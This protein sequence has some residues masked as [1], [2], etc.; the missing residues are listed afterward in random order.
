[1]RRQGWWKEEYFL[2]RDAAHAQVF[3]LSLASRLRALG[4]GALS[5]LSRNEAM[6]RLANYLGIFCVRTAAAT[7]LHLTELDVQF[8]LLHMYQVT[9]ANEESAWT[10]KRNADFLA[11]QL[12]VQQAITA[13]YSELVSQPSI[14]SRFWI[15][16]LQFQPHR[17]VQSY[18]LVTRCF[19]R[20][21]VV[22]ANIFGRVALSV[23]FFLVVGDT[24][25]RNDESCKAAGSR[26]YVEGVVGGLG[27][28]L[29]F[30]CISRLLQLLWTGI[31]LLFHS[32]E[33]KQDVQ[34]DAESRRQ[35]VTKWWLQ[36]VAFAALILLYSFG[37]CMLGT[38]YVASASDEDGQR[39]LASFAT[40][41]YD[42]E[43]EGY[44]EP[45]LEQKEVEGDAQMPPLEEEE[46]D[47]DEQVVLF[48]ESDEDDEFGPV[49]LA[50]LPAFAKRNGGE[51][52]SSITMTS[53]S[54]RSNSS[55]CRGSEERTGGKRVAVE[56][57]FI[58]VVDISGS[59]CE[60]D[61]KQVKGG[62]ISRIDAV[63]SEVRQLIELDGTRSGCD[64]RM[65]FITFSDKA[66]IHFQE[67][68]LPDAAKILST[69]QRPMPKGQTFYC[70]GLRA[71]A[72]CARQDKKRR[73]V[74]VVFLS[75]GEPTD[76]QQM[77]YTVQM[78]L[79]PTRPR[80]KELAVH[81]IGFGAGASAAALGSV[82]NQRAKRWKGEQEDDAFAYLYQLSAVGE[83]H[84]HR[85]SASTTSLRGAFKAV[86]STIT[87]SRTVSRSKKE[88][89]EE[90]GESSPENGEKR[91]KKKKERVEKAKTFELR[92]VIFDL[93]D[94]TEMGKR[95][96][97]ANRIWYEFDGSNFH[98]KSEETL[99]C[100]RRNPF[101]KGG[102]RH[103]YGMRDFGLDKQ[104]ERKKRTNMVAK[105]SKFVEQG[106]VDPLTTVDIYAK[107]TAVAHYY[108]KYF[109]R[110]CRKCAG[111]DVALDFVP[112][113]VYRPISA[114]DEEELEGFCGEQYVPGEFVKLTSNA[115][116]VNREEYGAHANIGAAFS[117]STFEW[118]RGA[119][120]VA[121]IQG[122]CTGRRDDGRSGK[123]GPCEED[124]NREWL[125]S[126]PQVLTD[127]AS[128][129]FGRGDLG[130]KGMQMFFKTH[131][132]G[133]LCKKLGLKDIGEYKEPTLRCYIPGSTNVLAGLHGKE[134]GVVKQIRQES[135]CSRLLIPREAYGEWIAVAIFA[136]SK[137]KA[138]HA[139]QLIKKRV[140]L[141]IDSYG[142]V[143]QVPATSVAT[144]WNAA[145][146]RS[147]RVEWIEKSGGAEI[148]LYRG[149]WMSDEP[150]EDG[151]VVS[152]YIFPKMVERGKGQVHVVFK[153]RDFAKDLIRK[154]VL[155]E[156]PQARAMV[157]EP[158]DRKVIAKRI[159]EFVRKS[160][161]RI[162]LATVAKQFAKDI[163]GERNA[164]EMDSYLKT[165]VLE[166]HDLLSYHNQMV[167][168]A[169]PKA[170]A[171][172]P[173]VA[174][175][176][177]VTSTRDFAWLDQT[178]WKE[179]SFHAKYQISR[180]FGRP[181]RPGG[182]FI[183]TKIQGSA[184]KYSI[185]LHFDDA[186]KKLWYGEKRK[187]YLSALSPK[188]LSWSDR[189]D[190]VAYV[191][192]L[193][194]GANQPPT[195]LAP[196][197]PKQTQEEWPV[198]PPS[199]EQKGS[200]P[201]Q[202]P[203][204]TTQSSNPKASKKGDDPWTAGKDP[205]AQA[206]KCAAQS[207]QKESPKVEQKETKAAKEA[208]R[209]DPAEEA[210]AA[211]IPPPPTQSPPVW[212]KY[213]DSTTQ[214]YWWCCIQNENKWFYEDDP[215]WEKFEVP[216]G[217]PM[218]A[219]RMYRWNNETQE[220]FFEDT[221]EIIGQGA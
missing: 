80:Q 86:T 11:L 32:R 167:L 18:S 44:D 92:N 107:Q 124:Q 218:G 221:G 161:G 47:E 65:S 144:S 204:Q 27:L 93:D 57:H 40:M 56:T 68:A 75:D 117:H 25:P 38:A 130:L 176:N 148:A 134:G 191:W 61:C 180:H 95:D 24:Q 16:F 112:C 36:D 101:T 219:G 197:A 91:K 33:F 125:L 111:L 37:C 48:N 13:S 137:S 64:D 39:W 14:R 127:G 178:T 155:G 181:G 99:V 186:T 123:H 89:E 106:D 189:Q 133:W 199:N 184:Q 188:R 21:C 78:E 17:A 152:I 43:D 28:Q 119:L 79:L 50:P 185:S 206:A 15:F 30:S 158:Q 196:K 4:C 1:M 170:P 19:M 131:K 187:W 100:V 162:E 177:S 84:F 69:M 165:L 157:S 147:K 202:E 74:D 115:G 146:W 58:V 160:G 163:G 214:K 109:R 62:A 120:L 113:Y 105:M 166:H 159:Q 201:A 12:K 2:T 116:F 210:P 142:V 67:V 34:W 193:I 220:C 192:E 104:A 103:C 156:E 164:L 110:E 132:C 203:A 174:E 190:N 195:K 150:K 10:R 81:C 143:V 171:Q 153:E 141:L 66:Q 179:A 216:E 128:Y 102:M 49:E 20:A 126:D 63:F 215:K 3:K 182:D 121:D 194:S 54:I 71:A 97:K 118:S 108:A 114:E 145:Y 169:A 26:Q 35:Q 6:S 82:P 72:S 42:D 212:Q 122:V 183:V 200:K 52:M 198:L 208:A 59:M 31:L 138:N 139:I 45:Y 8:M 70:E 205:W 211:D 46:E 213:L 7:K 73:P 209:Q 55:L 76:S 22:V 41:A 149:G 207:S 87:A 136:T 51:E 151:I 175:V 85:A 173:P 154:D 5:A 83:G 23:L 135:G 168:M 77:L 53:S 129:D 217:H 60:V 94:A 88:V 9:F 29:L 140:D 98:S 172:P 96:I 90:A